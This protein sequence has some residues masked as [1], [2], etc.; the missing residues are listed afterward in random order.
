MYQFE[1]TNR[2]NHRGVLV[3]ILE[4]LFGHVCSPYQ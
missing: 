3:L 2:G 4:T 1:H